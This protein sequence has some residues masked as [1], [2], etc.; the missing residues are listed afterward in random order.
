MLEVS[1]T[2]QKMVFLVREVVSRE[3]GKPEAAWTGLLTASTCFYAAAL[4]CTR[5]DQQKVHLSRII[6]LG[7]GESGRLQFRQ[8]ALR[9]PRG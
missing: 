3:N 8:T 4:C 6:N 5:H 2:V 7:K 1:D 9:K